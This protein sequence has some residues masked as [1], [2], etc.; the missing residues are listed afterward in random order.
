[1]KKAIAISIGL[2]ASS[3]LN[4][5]PGGL[6]ISQACVAEGCF[7]GDS[8]GFPVEINSP[9]SYFLSG[10]IEVGPITAS[11]IVINANDAKIDLNGFTIRGAST[12]DFAAATCT[13]GTVGRGIVLGGGDE[14][15]GISIIN[16]QIRGFD[17]YCA[18][19]GVSGYAADLVLTDC[20]AGIGLGRGAVGERIRAFNNRYGIDILSSAVV[21]DSFAFEN[22]VFGIQIN[23]DRRSIIQS[24]HIQSNGSNGIRTS[25]PTLISDCMISQNGS[26][27]VR[28]DSGSSGSKASGN[29]IVLNSSSGFVVSDLAGGSVAIDGNSFSDNLDGSPLNQISASIGSVVEIGVNMCGNTTE[30]L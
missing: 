25:S 21:R 3:Y 17:S 14:L 6:E 28:F 9:G 20:F 5:A 16:G 18:T 15:E 11:A 13:S 7:D 2:L 1:M 12:C 26:A 8:P 4:A 22:I 30:C 27:G 19:V 10:D 29:V 23:P 24:S